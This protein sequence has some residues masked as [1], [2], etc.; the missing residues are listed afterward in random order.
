MNNQAR[1]QFSS[2]S[3]SKI[4]TEANRTGPNGQIG[5]ASPMF[6]LGLTIPLGQGTPIDA[7]SASASD[8]TSPSVFSSRHSASGLS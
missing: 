2:S 6:Q 8:P 7:A 1:H 3:S 5:V 4:G